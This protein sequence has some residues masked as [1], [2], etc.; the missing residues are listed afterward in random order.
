MNEVFAWISGL[1]PD[2]PIF[3]IQVAWPIY[4][5]GPLVGLWGVWRLFWSIADKAAT[6]KALTAPDSA[7]KAGQ[8]KSHGMME[9]LA[10][11][12]AELTEQVARATA[13]EDPNASVDPQRQAGKAETVERIATSGSA[14]EI[15]ALNEIAKGDVKDGVRDLK[16]Q[17]GAIQAEADKLTAQKWRDIG[18]LAYD[19]EP[20]EALNAYREAATLDKSD[21]WAL[22]YLARLEQSHGD[23]LAAAASVLDE[24]LEA[25]TDDRDRSV[26]LS[27]LGDVRAHRRVH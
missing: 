11:K 10:A 22:I 7:T 12:V 15:A 25:V 19:R 6:L 14:A 16:Q 5:V 8:E 3:G 13:P 2:L 9:D 23:G 26:L 24:A 20:A 17:I 4:T 18:V 1:L 21:T 27:E